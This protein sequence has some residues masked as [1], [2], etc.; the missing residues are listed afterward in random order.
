MGFLFKYINK[1]DIDNNVQWVLIACVQQMD[2]S[3]EVSEVSKKYKN[4]DS[5][6]NKCIYKHRVRI[7]SNS[8]REQVS[9]FLQTMT[10][11]YFWYHWELA[12]TE[13]KFPEAAVC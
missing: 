6:F 13:A 4:Q 1:I 2:V 10:I 12:I 9:L 7:W 5:T 3:H 11:L 8:I